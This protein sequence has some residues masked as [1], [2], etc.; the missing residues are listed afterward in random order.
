MATL[1]GSGANTY[2]WTNGVTDGTAFTPT[3]TATYTVTGTDAN[4]CKATATQKITLNPLPNVSFSTGGASGGICPG[5][6]ATLTPS[7]AVTYTWT[8]TGATG[9]SAIVVT[10]SVTTSYTIVGTNALGCSNTKI[11]TIPLNP[12]PTVTVSAPAGICSGQTA[13]LT[14][15][16]TGTVTVGSYSWTTGATTASTTDSPTVT[17]T[18]TLFA[19]G[20]GGGS[21][22]DTVRTTITVGTLPSLT[23]TATSNP[24]CKGTRDTLTVSGATSYTW[25][26]TGSHLAIFS[27]VANSS[28]TFTV[29]GSNNGCNDS[30][31]ITISVNPSP[32]VTIVSN[33]ANDT[34]CN[35][36]PI[37]LTGAGAINY[38]WNGGVTNGTAFSPTVT[39]T[40]TVVGTDANGCS[41]AKS[42]QVV[43]QT[44]L[45]INQHSNNDTQVSVYPNPSNGNFSI[46]VANFENTS[47]EVYNSLGEKIYTKTLNSNT[48]NIN[49][50][51][52]YAGVY[53]MHVKQNG[54]YTYRNNIVLTK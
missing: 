23:V 13:T 46:S 17:T 1:I 3:T 33:P 40:Y 45:G 37:T 43:V 49:I 53:F 35:G 16:S 18:Y 44:C 4:G 31:T 51:K 7:G 15:T 27:G 20:T 5:A 29:I 14:A 52:F 39:A 36:S 22:T 32:T 50:E 48:E 25:N 26:P 30:T 10:P 19:S 24:V 34:I 2:S 54:V 6:S 38:V 42:V 28:A 9:S 12:V 47:V 21:C 11:R 41:K 8:N